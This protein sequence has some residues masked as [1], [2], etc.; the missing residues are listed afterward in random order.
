MTNNRMEVET[1]KSGRSTFPLSTLHFALVL[2][3]LSA[4]AALG[5]TPTWRYEGFLTY[6]DNPFRYSR[7]DL[8]AFRHREQPA[9]FP[10]RTSDD[11]DANIAVGLSCGTRLLRMPGTIETGLKLHGYFSNWEKTYAIADLGLNQGTWTGGRLELGYTYMPGYLLRYYR[12]P[13][14]SDTGDY[15]ACRFAEHLATLRLRQQFGALTVLPQYG[16][17]YDDYVPVF[18]HYDARIHRFGGEVRFHPV[19]N[20]DARAEY[21]YRSAAARGPVPDAS[22]A[23]HE[24]GL[25]VTTSPRR[26]ARFSFE[27]GYSFAWRSYTTL[28]SSAVDPSHAGRKDNTGVATVSVK[29]RLAD[30][31]L[32]ADYNLE[33]REVV[34]AYST[35]IDDIKD[36]R[37]SRLGLGVVYSSRKGKVRR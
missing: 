4:G 29:Y 10:I 11:L 34:S 31:T 30:F 17:E 5:L 18:D 6:D 24:A 33:W 7:I 35:S 37:R 14:T 36:Y 1:P 9:R 13:Q 28:N 12:N 15:A 21:E 22:Y 23:Q 19:E 16:F 20:L 27:A 8:D 32:A 25:S 26:L 2:T 3:V